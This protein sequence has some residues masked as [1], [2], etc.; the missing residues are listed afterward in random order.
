[1]LM[2][3]QFSRVRSGIFSLVIILAAA[4]PCLPVTKSGEQSPVSLKLVQTLRNSE[5][6]SWD[7]PF[8]KQGLL[9]VRRGMWYSSG[10]L[11]PAR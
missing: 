4:S 8:S 11:N 5:L 9:A 2:G 6:A 10:T 1:M 7:E 3:Q